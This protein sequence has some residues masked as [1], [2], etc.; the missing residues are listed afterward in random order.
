ML[1]RYFD[2]SDLALAGD[3]LFAFLVGLGAVMVASDVPVDLDGVRLVVRLGAGAMLL[4]T[5][6]AGVAIGRSASRVIG[7]GA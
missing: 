1:A 4:A 7:G 3:A 2:R 6:V 5:F